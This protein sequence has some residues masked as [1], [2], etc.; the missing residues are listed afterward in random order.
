MENL[1]N[2]HELKGAIKTQN[3]RQQRA[4]S[5]IKKLAT[6]LRLPLHEHEKDC[7]LSQPDA[8]K[9]RRTI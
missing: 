4:R 7:E 6:P 9:N 3:W 5:T 8:E 2:T 1:A